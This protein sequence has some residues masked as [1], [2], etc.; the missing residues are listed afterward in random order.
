MMCVNCDRERRAY[1]LYAHVDDSNSAVE[2]SF[3]SSAC[4]DQWV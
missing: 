2:L 1:T 3:C 4:L